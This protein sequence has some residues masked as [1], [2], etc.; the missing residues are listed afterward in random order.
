LPLGQ[1]VG[2]FAVPGG[3]FADPLGCLLQ[4]IVGGG[5]RPVVLERGGGLGFGRTERGPR[6]ARVA[7]P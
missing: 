5:G 3:Q 4:V 2:E 7:A 1:L 6:L